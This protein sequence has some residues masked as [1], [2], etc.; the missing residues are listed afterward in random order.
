MKLLGKLKALQPRDFEHLVFD[1][2]LLRGLRNMSW[3]TPGSDGGRDIEGDYDAGD[4]SG[5]NRTERWYV[6]CKRHSNT[7]DW[8]TVYG[9][10]AYADSHA[11]DFLLICTTG[12]LSPQCKDE[13]TKHENARKRPRLR[14]WEGALLE[15]LV[16][17]EPLLMS[18]YDLDASKKNRELSVLPL[19]TVMAKTVHQAYGETAKPT[20][21]TEF[22]AA[23]AEFASILLSPIRR[24][25]ESRPFDF[26]RDGYS[27]LKIQG[28]PTNIS[29]GNY[30]VRMLVTAVKFLTR[31]HV[32]ELQFGGSRRK[33]SLLQV[34]PAP[35]LN[36]KVVREVLN[37]VSVL[38]NWEWHIRKGVLEI[39]V[40]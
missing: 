28:K 21:A 17:E 40:R 19:L 10:L 24:V 34:N 18:K 15:V 3:R 22:A 20:P 5:A 27:W 23:T 38:A 4:F 13:I 6:E 37:A 32:V 12:S 39:V 16:S 25:H 2:L 7:V 1:L 35:L 9:K 14:A 31:T 26:K 33:D 29:W 11:A 30:E 36:S 8:P